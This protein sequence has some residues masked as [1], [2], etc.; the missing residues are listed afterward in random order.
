MK[1]ISISKDDNKLIVLKKTKELTEIDT[2]EDCITFIHKK[3]PNKGKISSRELIGPVNTDDEYNL[4]ILYY[5]SPINKKACESQW[6]FRYNGKDITTFNG[7][8]VIKS[9]NT[10][11]NSLVN[12]KDFIEDD[13]S[14]IRNKLTHVEENLEEDTEEIDDVEDNDDEG[15]VLNFE[16]GDTNLDD[17]DENSEKGGDDLFDDDDEQIP[18]ISQINSN[19]PKLEIE[20]NHVLNFENYSYESEPIPQKN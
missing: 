11:L 13:I 7:I 2:E 20:Q 4:W 17:D 18:I 8:V 10:V 19:I 1:W 3:N 16:Y 6:S 9:E 5:T 14:L 12:T 15:D